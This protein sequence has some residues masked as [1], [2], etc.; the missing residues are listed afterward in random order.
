MILNYE[1][2]EEKNVCFFEESLLPEF[3]K[4]DGV[5]SKKIRFEKHFSHDG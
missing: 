5:A 3:R 2:L 1:C 4:K